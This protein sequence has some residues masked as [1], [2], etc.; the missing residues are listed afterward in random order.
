[1]EAPDSWVNVPRYLPSL[2]RGRKITST[3]YII[4]LHLRVCCDQYGKCTTSV[5]D[6]INDLYG[7]N[8]GISHDWINKNLSSLRKKRIILYKDR[9]GVGGPFETLFEDFTLPDGHYSKF[10]DTVRQRIV[11]PKSVSQSCESSNVT[12]ADRMSDKPV[13]MICKEDNPNLKDGT[14]AGSNTD[15]DTDNDKDT[16]PV[17]NR[18]KGKT[19]VT[20]FNPTSQDEAQVW[21]IAKSVED[22]FMDPYLN[23]INKGYMWAIEKGFGEFKESRG[24]QN[25]AAYLYS[26]IKRLIDEAGTDRMG[27][28]VL[29]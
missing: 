25:K 8:Q 16:V 7:P 11:L 12:R 10:S 14:V 13:H 5:D 26:I 2:L 4:Y 24:V 18:W 1:M 20:G 6:I 23:L 21:E 3:E 22:D 9:K 19:P 15:K 17:S 28:G 27:G 29:V